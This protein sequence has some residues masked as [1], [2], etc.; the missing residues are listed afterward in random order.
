MKKYIVIYNYIISIFIYN[1]PP[2]PDFWC[3]EGGG[4][5]VNFPKIGACG[6]LETCYIYYIGGIGY[7]RQNKNYKYTTVDIRR[8]SN[9]YYKLGF[10]V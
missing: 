2:S 4:V 8:K 9:L 7:Y 5:Y 6:G 3:F 1:P 10:L